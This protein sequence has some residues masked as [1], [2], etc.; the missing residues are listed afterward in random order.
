MA[1]LKLLGHQEEHFKRIC[2]ILMEEFGYLD[3]SP[4]RTGKTYIVLNI[5]KVFKL[6]LVIICPLTTVPMWQKLCKLYNINLSNIITYQSLRGNSSIKL[7]N[8]LLELNEGKYKATEYF[9]ELVKKGILLVFDESHY[10]KNPTAQLQSAHCL[11]KTVVELNCGSRIGLL[12]ATPCDKKEH[13]ESL[14]KMLGIINNDKLYNYDNNLKTYELLGIQEVI[15]K[16]NIIDNIKTNE[17]INPIIIDKKTVHQVC[18]DLYRHVIKNRVSSS[19]IIND[20][21]N[22][23]I[24]KIPE[25]NIKN[26]YYNLSECSTGLVMKGMNLLVKATRYRGDNQSIDIKPGS[27]GDITNGLMLIEEGKIEIM[28]RLT[29][30]ILK[31]NNN[32]K[33]ILYCNFISNMKFLYS[34]LSEYNPLL[35]YGQTKS[36]WRDDIINKFQKPSNEFRLLISNPKVGGLGISLDDRHGDFPRYMFIIPSHDFTNLHQATG[37][38]H[39]GTETKSDSTIRFIYSKLFKQETSILNNLFKK[40]ITTR[41]ILYN[42]KGLIFPGEYENYIEPDDNNNNIESIIIDYNHESEIVADI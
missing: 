19:M 22:E 9:I 33:V 12:S 6:S 29:K 21:N 34:N 37:R 5:A 25:K 14:L 17:I 39:C 42:D 20:N 7:T 24:I 11:A 28:I 8:G 13:S 3:T 1:E 2:D 35:M 15:D 41:N 18:Y 31:N 10:L 40:A 27:W 4:V 32:A 30:N 26:G 23:N 16:S 36:N 38:I